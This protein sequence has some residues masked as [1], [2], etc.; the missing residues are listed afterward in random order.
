MATVKEI[1]T[2][3]KAGQMEEAYELAKSDYEN[4]PQN[5]WTQRELGWALYY[6]LKSDVENNKRQMFYSH[7]EELS[8]LDLLTMQ[9]N[10]ILFD[11]LIWKFVE[12]AK[13]IPKDRTDEIDLIYIFLSKYTF[14]SSTAYSALLKQ[15]LH[16]EKWN[17]FV[18]FFE[19]WNIDNLTE[20]DYQPFKLENGRMSMSLAE[21]VY[22]A[23]SKALLVL[24]DKD[25]IR[26]FLPKIEKLMDDYPDMM[27]PRYYCRKLKQR[28]N[29]H[30]CIFSMKFRFQ[31]HLAFFNL[32]SKKY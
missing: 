30:N 12:V 17:R 23:Y 20:K 25:R 10:A 3:C 6:S 28:I 9:D 32:K 24:D 5:V 19:W 18:E 16:F 27:Y 13:L 2:M 21:Q 15:I 4:D 11:N 7:L 26:D 8:R 31:I 14:N 29:P 22:I 1:T